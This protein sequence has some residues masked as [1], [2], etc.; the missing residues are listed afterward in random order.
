MLPSIFSL[1]KIIRS[2]IFV[3]SHPSKKTCNKRETTTTTIMSVK[4]KSIDTDNQD[5]NL[6]SVVNELM[7]RKVIE[8]EEEVASSLQ[9]SDVHVHEEFQEEV[10]NS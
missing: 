5:N 4:T 6:N 7:N 3:E 2:K 10:L 8:H 9:N 1:F